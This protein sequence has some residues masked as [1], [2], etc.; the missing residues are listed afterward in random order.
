MRNEMDRRPIAGPR[1]LRACIIHRVE[2]DADP[3]PRPYSV[4]NQFWTCYLVDNGRVLK[5]A[6]T[7][8]PFAPVVQIIDVPEW[9]V[10]KE[11]D[12]GGY[13]HQDRTGNGA[14]VHRLVFEADRRSGAEV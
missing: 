10:V 5:K 2:G 12:K 14:R 1:K 4:R 8:R 3:V 9:N 6:K 11:D 13:D 7:I